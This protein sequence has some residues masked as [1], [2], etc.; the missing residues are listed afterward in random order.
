MGVVIW[1]LFTVMIAL[2][3]WWAGLFKSEQVEDREKGKR[4][5]YLGKVSD[6]E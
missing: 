1:V 6:P 2:G 5:E 3:T 4:E